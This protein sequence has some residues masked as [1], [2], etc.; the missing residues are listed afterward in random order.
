[1]LTLTVPPTMQW[2]AGDNVGMGKD[3]TLFAKQPGVVVY[4]ESKYI[5]K[6]CAFLP[7]SML[8]DCQTLC[9]THLLKQRRLAHAQGFYHSV[10]RKIFSLIC[11]H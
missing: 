11:S 10:F 1:M 9:L 5:R 4:Q 3:Y 6:V 8:C 7:A 2:H